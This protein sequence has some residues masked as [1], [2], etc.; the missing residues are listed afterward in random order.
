M[1]NG[2]ENPEGRDLLLAM[3]MLAFR[4]LLHEAV[5]SCSYEHGEH[6]MLLF[7]PGVSWSERTERALSTELLW[8]GFPALQFSKFCDRFNG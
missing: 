4:P 6:T 8:F 7:G 3:S 2:G 1:Q 5:G